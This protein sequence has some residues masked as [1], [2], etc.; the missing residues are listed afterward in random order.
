MKVKN[1]NV[2]II[3]IFGMVLIFPLTSVLS[4]YI[5][6]EDEVLTFL[7]NLEIIDA[8]NRISIKDFLINLIKDFHP[9]GRNLFSVPTI[10]LFGEN[11]TALRLPY[12]ILWIFTC[13]ISL[14]IIQEF[15]GNRQTIYLN[16]LLI[17]GTGIFHIQIMGFGHGMVTFLGIFL[18]YKLIIIS[19]NKEKF[20]SHK[21]FNQI[22]LLSFLGFLFF[23]TFILLTFNL[24]LIQF[25]LIL[26]HDKKELLLFS[27]ISLFQFFLYL[28]YYLIFLGLPYLLVNEP[29]SFIPLIENFFG[30]LNFGNW[31]QA[32]FGQYHQYILR[33]NTL[34]LN[35]DSLMNNLKYLNWHFFP[36]LGVFVI[37]FGMYNLFRNTKIIF[38]YIFTYFL[39][40]N[41]L[42]VGNT[43]QHFLSSF[44]WLI[45][46][47]SLFLT[48]QVNLLGY[49]IPKIILFSTI[50]SFT[51]FFHI[52]I[53]H[54]KNYPY[55]IMNSV[56][57]NLKWPPN[58]KRPLKQ[59]SDDLKKYN[60][61]KE[62]IYYTIDGSIV[63]YYLNDYNSIKINKREIADKSNSINCKAL[64]NDINYLIT[65]GPIDE[66]CN[67]VVSQ[68]IHYENSYI[69][70][71][72]R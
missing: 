42:M 41:F 63:H 6:G 25:F 15:N 45:P 2:D 23:N 49:L 57:G 10:M 22:T 65:T 48:R 43:G 53:Y 55:K 35:Y 36:Y 26:K 28:S 32:P 8:L 11:I 68:V 38:L 18:I 7:V 29:Q 40:V 44:V 16:T 66:K 21:L 62:V 60:L 56:N 50:I 33:Q 52:Y 27:I 9:P 37:I 13:F 72:I 67:N 19:K 58:L 51:I 71:I 54:E 14:K 34:R 17:S 3:I 47:F 70:L 64:N 59:V 1:K 4:P 31:D 12:Y 5:S 30:K 69:K 61:Y 24:F 39:F 20:I 46:F